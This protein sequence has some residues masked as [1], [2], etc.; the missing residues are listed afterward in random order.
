MQ[1]SELIGKTVEEAQ[2]LCARAGFRCRVIMEDGQPLFGTC[3]Y[4]LGRRN[5]MVRDGLVVGVNVEGGD[6]NIPVPSKG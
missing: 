2:T 5:F 1:N 4:V 3:D 6:Q